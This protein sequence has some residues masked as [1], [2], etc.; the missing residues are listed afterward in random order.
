MTR[1][2]VLPGD[3][4][5]VGLEDLLQ[6]GSESSSY[7]PERKPLGFEPFY[8][9]E[10]VK[11]GFGINP[12]TG[13]GLLGFRKQSLAHV[14]IDGRARDAGGFFQLLYAEWPHDGR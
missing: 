8:L 5:D 7:L 11:M 14:E 3:E 9:S 1:L 10:E 12:A 2:L 4:V 13:R 6:P